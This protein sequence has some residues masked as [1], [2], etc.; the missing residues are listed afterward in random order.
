[1]FRGRIS[2]RAFLGRS[3]L[4]ST[5]LLATDAVALTLSDELPWLPGQADGAVAY[6]EA[7]YL[8]DAERRCVD[9]ITAR[10][11]PSDD[12]GPG[13]RDAGVTDFIDSQLAGFYGRGER[14]YM[15]GP[16]VEGTEQQGYQSEL[17]P[18]ALYR[19]AIEALDAHCRDRFGDRAFADLPEEEQDAVLGRIDE[20]ELELDGISAKGFFGL[21]R[22][23]AI[24]G[25]FCDPIYGGNRDMVGWKLVGFPGARYDYRD[26]LDHDG[27]PISIEP[28]GLRG[29]P[30]WN[31]A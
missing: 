13:A 10:L 22:E 6:P 12:A 30:A 25:F 19:K 24:E 29:R 5:A 4:G 3:V 28:V 27:E 23:N 16:F 26:F 31:P 1:M 7:R 14:W 8:T 17:P 11:I 20:G 9:A 21:V 18:A 2:R 15:R